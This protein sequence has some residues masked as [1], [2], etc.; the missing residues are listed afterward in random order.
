MAEKKKEWRRELA[1]RFAVAAIVKVL[2]GVI[3]E[4]VIRPHD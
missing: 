4:L 1:S 2:W 3:F